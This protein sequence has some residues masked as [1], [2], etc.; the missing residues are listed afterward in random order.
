M[1]SKPGGSI[2]RSVCQGPAA[3]QTV[4]AQLAVAGMGASTP[5]VRDATQAYWQ[6]RIDSQERPAMWMKLPKFWIPSPLHGLHRNPMCRIR[7][8][9][10]RHPDSGVLWDK[11]LIFITSRLGWV[12]REMHPGL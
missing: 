1:C 12:R 3:L 8:A 5:K 7:I 2:R 6:S 11:L 10:H 9:S 4:R